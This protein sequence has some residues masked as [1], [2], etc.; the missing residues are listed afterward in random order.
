MADSKSKPVHEIRLGSVKAVIWE[1]PTK[2]GPRHNV[3]LVRLYKDGE[4]WKQT[5]SFGRD[6]LPLVCKVAD[7]AHSWIFEQAVATPNAE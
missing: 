7:L 4:H 6:E 5:E 3:S 2:H 1:N